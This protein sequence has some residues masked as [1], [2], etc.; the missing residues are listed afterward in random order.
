MIKNLGGVPVRIITEPGQYRDPK[1]LWHSWNVDRLY[2][3]GVK[4]RNRKHAGWLHQKT[5]LLRGQGM[6][7]F[8]S[9]NWTSPSASSQLEH[10]IFTKDPSFYNFFK[11]MFERKWTN[12]TGTVETTAFVP[13]APDRPAY[14][15]PANANSGQPLTVTLKWKAG[16]WA[17]KY[18]IYFGTS[19]TAPRIARDVAL[20]HSKT[21]TDYK[22]YT[23]TGL[24]PNRTYYWRIVSKTIANVAKSGP[25]WSIRTGV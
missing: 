15:S 1:R 22:S 4:I 7:I 20:G 14:V 2:V 24:S 8:G 12:S 3:A 10:N 25:V 6:T 16:Y 9:S 17:H 23:V 19:S 21:S 11:S 13:L 5:T 18:D